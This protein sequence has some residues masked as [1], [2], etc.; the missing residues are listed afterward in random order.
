MINELPAFLMT[1]STNFIHITNHGK[2]KIY[3]QLQLFIQDPLQSS[4]NLIET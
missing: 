4:F 3:L 2:V 1:Q